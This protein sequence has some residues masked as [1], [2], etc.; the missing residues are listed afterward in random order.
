MPYTT[1]LQQSVWQRNVELGAVHPSLP[2]VQQVSIGLEPAPFSRQAG[3]QVAK[4][5]ASLPHRTQWTGQQ[6]AGARPRLRNQFSSNCQQQYGRL[7]VGRSVQESGQ[8]LQ[9]PW[10]H[11]CQNQ[12]L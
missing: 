12:T 10:G 1:L 4:P 5:F 8:N 6:L 9:A 11:A 2:A 7:D 3:V